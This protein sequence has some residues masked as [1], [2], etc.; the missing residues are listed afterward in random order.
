MRLLALQGDLT[1]QMIDTNPFAASNASGT[2]E[3]IK[4]R[5][6]REAALAVATSATTGAFAALP[7]SSLTQLQLRIAIDL[8]WRPDGYWGGG[9]GGAG[10]SSRR[11]KRAAARA[12]L[13]L[14]TEACC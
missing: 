8:E 1:A 3:K 5:L 14:G 2:L 6:R 11:H 12:K 10:G 4:S 9:S 13:P 7:S